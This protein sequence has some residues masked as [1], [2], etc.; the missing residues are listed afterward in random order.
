LADIRG[1][2]VQQCSHQPVLLQAH[3]NRV[4]MKPYR[5]RSCKSL[6]IKLIVLSNFISLIAYYQS[7]SVVF[8]KSLK[9]VF[10]DSTWWV[11]GGYFVFTSSRWTLLFCKKHL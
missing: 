11:F 8:T 10:Y 7:H 5:M 2:R 4:L 3:S 1:R 6:Y 9:S